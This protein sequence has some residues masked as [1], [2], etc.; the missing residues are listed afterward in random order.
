MSCSSVWG[1][2]VATHCELCPCVVWQ[3]APIFPPST[4]QTFT[5]S[6]GLPADAI[7]SPRTTLTPYLQEVTCAPPISSRLGRTPLWALRATPGLPH[8]HY[9]HCILA[10]HITQFR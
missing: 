1:V 10:L 9:L 3:V 4:C 7:L 6:E 2:G 5:R 8:T